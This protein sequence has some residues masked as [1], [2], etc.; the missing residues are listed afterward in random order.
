[1]DF[2]KV[3]NKDA[4][5]NQNN[6]DLDDKQIQEVINQL[7]FLKEFALKYQQTKRQNK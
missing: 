5:N 7:D 4:K 6:H 3:I 1:M 2:Y